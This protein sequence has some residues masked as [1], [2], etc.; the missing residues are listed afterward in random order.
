MECD[1]IKNSTDIRIRNIVMHLIALEV[2]RRSSY[3]IAMKQMPKEFSKTAIS[4]MYKIVEMNGKFQH[5]K[6]IINLEI[7]TFELT[8][9]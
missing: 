7:K 5:C 4:Q 3:W 6:D 8:T 9:R 2:K 1:K